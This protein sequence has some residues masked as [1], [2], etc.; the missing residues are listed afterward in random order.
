[1]SEAETFHERLMRL[2]AEK[3]YAGAL[4][5]LRAPAPDQEPEGDYDAGR[6]ENVARI[7]VVK[8]LHVEAAILRDVARRRLGPTPPASPGEAA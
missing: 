4:A 3:D 2:G 1:M 8:G 7:C 5:L 6:L